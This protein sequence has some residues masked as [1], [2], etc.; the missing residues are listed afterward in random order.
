VADTKPVVLSGA[1]HRENQT[2][3]VV[4]PVT[5]IKLVAGAAAA[6]LAPLYLQSG[7]LLTTPEIGA[8]E[9]LNHTG[10]LTTY[11]VRRSFDLSWSTV[12]ADVPVNDTVTETTIYS[13]AN[14]ANFHTVGKRCRIFLS[15]IYSTFNAASTFTMR[16]KWG[17]TTMLTLTSVGRTVT[18]QGWHA[19]FVSTV[20]T[21]GA[22]GTVIAFAKADVDNISIDGQQAAATVVD[23]T[24]DSTFNV[25]LQWSAANAGNTFTLQQGHTQSVN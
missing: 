9:F 3:D 17:T 2:G 20:R 8:V 19:D 21:I 13:C 11:L 10:Y 23:T 25:T 18:A 12:V 22:T 1:R 4:A 24:V 6:G 16:F 7:P 15:G 5:P 14:A